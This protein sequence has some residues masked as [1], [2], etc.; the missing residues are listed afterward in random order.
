VGAHCACD[1]L[2]LG[3]IALPPRFHPRKD[4]P[5][6]GS[7]HFSGETLILWGSS[8]LDLVKLLEQHFFL[9][10]VTAFPAQAPARVRLRGAP[11][12]HAISKDSIVRARVL[13]LAILAI[14]AM[15]WLSPRTIGFP[16]P[17]GGSVRAQRGLRL[18]H[19]GYIGGFPRQLNPSP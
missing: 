8:S 9:R 16:H 14:A 19:R 4:E 1:S 5:L 11:A 12:L 15:S 17:L 6:R 13:T 3:T 10:S 7:F 2:A 18:R